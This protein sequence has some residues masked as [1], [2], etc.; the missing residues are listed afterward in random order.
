[1]GR[2]TT[3][4]DPSYMDPA[5]PKSLNRYAYAYNNPLRYNDPTGHEPC[6]PPTDT[7]T[8]VEGHPPDIGLIQFLINSL[9]RTRG[10]AQEV[11]QP[12]VNW[13]IAPRDPG[14]MN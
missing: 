7:S 10:T 3:P 2:F 11:A 13:I 12:V 6:P 14:C 5:N 4:D 9:S 8:C 1:I